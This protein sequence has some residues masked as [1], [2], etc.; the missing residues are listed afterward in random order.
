V[1]LFLAACSD[2]EY[3]ISGTFCLVELIG[4]GLGLGL[5]GLDRITD[6]LLFEVPCACGILQGRNYSR[7]E[8][9]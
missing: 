9:Q 5:S 1:L 3:R 8:Y 2:C 6:E 4:H 7:A